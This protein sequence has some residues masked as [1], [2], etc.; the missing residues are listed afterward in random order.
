MVDDIIGQAQT[1]VIISLVGTFLLIALSFFFVRR[2][3][4]KVTG[5]NIQGGEVAQAT[6]IRMWDTGTTVNDNPV[7]GFLLEVRRQAYPVYQAETKSMIPRL[8][9]SQFQ[10]GAVVPIKLNPQNP[11]QVALNL[12]A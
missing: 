9:V 6:I 11:T 10:P 1:T 4:R 3:M 8:M 5:G 12:Y 2:Y 7:V